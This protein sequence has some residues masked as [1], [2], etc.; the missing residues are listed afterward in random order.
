MMWLVRMALKRPYTFVVMSMLIVIVG[1]L[2]IS[3]MP[4]DIFPDIDIPV[5]SVVFNYSGLSPED[6]EKRM[7]NNFERFLTTVVNDIEHIESQSLTGIAVIKIF[8][9]PGAKIEAATAQVTAVSQAAIR[10]MPPG[11]T[12]PFIIRY[13]ASNV[14]ILQV[15]LESD[16]LSEQ[17]LFDYGINFVRADLATIQGVQMP[18]PYGGKQRL[19]MIDIDPQRLFAWG[20][21]PRDVTTAI[22]QQNVIVPTGTAKI[23]PNEFPIVLNSSPD[24]L[25]QIEAIPVK[26]VRGTAVYVRDV[27]YVRDGYSPQTNIVHVEGRRSVLM[28]IL[29]QGSASTLDIVRRIRETLPGT[30]ARLPKELK[31][32]LLFDQSIFVRASIEGVVKEA[33]IAAGLTALMLL[34]FLGSWRSTV[35]VIISIPLS[36]LVSIIALASLGET[37]NVMTLGG[38]ALAVGILVDDATVEI[39]NVHRNMA[40]KKPILR[41]ILDG[42]AEIATPAFVS[43]L[44]ICIV[45]VPVVFISGSAKS[46]FIPL[47]MSVVFAM[48]TSYFLSRTLVPTMMRYLMGPEAERHAQGSAAPPPRWFGARLIARFE[49]GFER[50]RMSYGGLLASALQHRR[51]VVIG[52]LLFVVASLSL[53]PLVGRDFFPTVDAGLIKLHV[54]GVPGTRIEETERKFVDIE[55]A[56]RQVIPAEEIQT[57]L[58]NV[59]IPYSGLNLSLSEGALISAA[60]GEIFI[61]LKKDH[62]P[63]EQYVRKMRATLAEKFPDQTFFFLAPDISTQVLNF[64]LPAPIDVQVLGA[65]GNEDATYEVARQI[66]RRVAEIPGA[67]DVHMAQVPKQPQLRIDVDRTMAGKVGLTERD[68]A[69]D[70]LVALASSAVVSPSYWLDKRGVQYLVAVQTPQKDINSIDAVKT[71]PLSNGTERP[72]L[73]SNLASISRT[74]GPVN[75]THYNIARTYDVQANVEGTDLGSV[76]D[77]VEKI[78]EELKP[79]MP[80]GTTVRIKGQAESMQSSFR[81]LAFGLIFAILLVYLLMVVNFQSWL[82]PLV[83]LMALPGAMAGI[84]WILFLAHTT[85]SVPA[86]MGSIMC[87]GVATANSILVVTFANDMRETGFDA[88]K[89]AL[90]AGMTRLRPVIMTALAMILGMLPMSLG[91]GEG[92]EQNAPLGR[93]VIGGL[94]L[95]TVTTLFF[96]PVMYSLLRRKPPTPVDPELEK[97]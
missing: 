67:V 51:V 6:M 27:A 75:I 31:V 74:A 10:S 77:R 68:V 37:L 15:A 50:M 5:I 16:A 19:I 80:R 96:V 24:L 93:A 88:A 62:R 8:F 58:D 85:L 30:L 32:K 40:Q 73:L 41:A 82:D 36:I 14:P 71:L 46:L 11:T 87:V 38:M 89:A 1:L 79:S 33:L 29:K 57:L 7:V 34:V 35:I 47:A 61:A 72:Q 97:V 90:A 81:G 54:R 17:Q 52:F 59:G 13:S 18:Y 66:G 2:T 3:R 56:I 9:Q 94:L 42:A 76:T 22:T 83:I 70:L 49:R 78:V 26:V 64:G 53:L 23:G 95:A 48:L 65:I 25:A 12:P 43:T 60:D 45:F 44:C 92:G 86:L 69:S 20:F 84:A 4:T 28:S 55:D 91:L 39:E 21:S 63:T